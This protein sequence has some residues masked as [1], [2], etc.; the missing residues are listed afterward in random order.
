MSVCVLGSVSYGDVS[1]HRQAVRSQQL[2]ANCQYY[3]VV[4]NYACCSRN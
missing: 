1:T 4:I 3:S 2:P